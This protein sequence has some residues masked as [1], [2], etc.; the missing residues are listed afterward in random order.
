MRL[1]LWQ[2]S[3]FLFCVHD[4]GLGYGLLVFVALLFAD[5]VIE[6]IE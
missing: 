6:C 5:I 2:V 1:G 4:F 3:T